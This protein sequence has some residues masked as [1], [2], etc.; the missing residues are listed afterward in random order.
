MIT[1]PQFEYIK[2]LLYQR[3]ITSRKTG[4]SATPYEIED[5]I[6]EAGTLTK[7]DASRW[8]D[9]LKSLPYL[10][11]RPGTPPK[12]DIDNLEG[13]EYA[14]AVLEEEGVTAEEIEEGERLGALG[15]LADLED[16]VPAGRYALLRG[17]AGAEVTW[18]FYRVDKP[19]KGRWAGRTFLKVYASDETFPIKSPQERASVM[20][21]IVRMGVQ[22][23][24]TAYGRHIGSCGVCGR[25]LTD[26]DSRARGIGPI[27]AGKMGWE[28]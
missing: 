11:G 13:E 19:T 22:E 10:D 24:S 23:S 7:G 4:Q 14:Q 2:A 3:K 20:S 18:K 21:Q 1:K 15:A 8:I 12:P 17:L 26:E 6:V 16:L 5:M 25:T 27:C 28:I 9:R